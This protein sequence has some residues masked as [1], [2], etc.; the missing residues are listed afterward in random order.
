MPVDDDNVAGARLTGPAHLYPLV[1]CA[2]IVPLVSPGAIRRDPELS[3]G[4]GRD[5][6]SG[7]NIWAPQAPSLIGGFVVGGVVCARVRADER[8]PR[9][10]ERDRDTCGHTRRAASA[11]SRAGGGLQHAGGT[12]G[13]DRRRRHDRGDRDRLGRGGDRRDRL[14]CARGGS[15]EPPHLVA[16]IAV[17][18][19]ARARRRS[20]RGGARRRWDR[21]GSMGRPERLATGRRLRRP[22]CARSLAADRS[23]VG[24]RAHPAQPACAP[25]GDASSPG[26]DRWCRVGHGGWSLF[27]SRGE[28][29]TEVD[30][31]DRRAAPRC[32]QIADVRGSALGEGRLRGWRSRS[33]PRWADGE[34]SA[35]SAV[36]SST[37][38]RS[39]VSP[40]RPARLRSS[41]PPRTWGPRSRPPTSSSPRSSGSAPGGAAG[42]TSA[43]PSSDRSPSPGS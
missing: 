4:P 40:A 17:E 39:T 18:L 41:S 20:R 42:G 30:G 14:G 43:G 19:C 2:D 21:C 10:R 33:E 3:F 37:W 11:G 29:C 31:S 7:C 24:V 15:L 36:G 26:P 23:R 38:R 1:L 8:L 6:R 34:S 13:W 16:R 35:R 32:G 25:P 27:Q 5:R 9:R 12:P 22:D 28:R